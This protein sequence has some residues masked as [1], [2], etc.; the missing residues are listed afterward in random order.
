[1]DAVTRRQFI[2][3]AGAG[4]GSARSAGTAHAV[5]PTA[6]LT[7][8]VVIDRITRSLGT[9][10]QPDGVA[11]FKAGDPA[12]PV[13]GIVT[14]AMA[15]LDVLKGTVRAGANL[16]ITLEP[17]FYGRADGA[18]AT[19]G[20]E[21]ARAGGRPRS[22]PPIPDPVLSAKQEYIR[23]NDL[24]VWRVGELWRARRPDPLAGALAEAL[25]LS[26]PEGPAQTRSFHIAPTHLRRLVSH[27]QTSLGARG[28]VRA[29]GN[30]DL[31]IRRV[32]L[33]PGSTPLRAVLDLLPAVDVVVAGEMREWEGV[34]YVRD[35]VT[36]GAAKG[37]VLV[38]RVLSE[39]PGMHACGRWLET[40]VPEVRTRWIRA[41][42]PYWRPA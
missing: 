11:G 19:A 28:G 24:I 3:L 20:G 4:L 7:G 5:R 13:T 22:A 12:R 8:R 35:Q 15:T 31:P 10:G 40:L 18:T 25:G 27:A 9:G 42:D 33:L 16:V 2:S 14:T 30:P 6:A 39:E 37:L 41:G 21:I 36:S 23:R 38:G 1:M 26:A 29:V 17:A 32:G 34:E